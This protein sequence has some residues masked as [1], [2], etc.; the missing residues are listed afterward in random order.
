MT[1]FAEINADRPGRILHML[2]VI[3]T[4]ARSNK[5]E[6]SEVAE[7][8]APVRER[9]DRLAPPE[10]SA[11]EWAHLTTP[12]APPASAPESIEDAPPAESCYPPIPRHLTTA[13][14]EVALRERYAA[15]PWGRLAI[16]A[17]FEPINTESAARAAF[18]F[19]AELLAKHGV[20]A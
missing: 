14:R 4:S 17:G 15:E 8:L 18:R 11:P 10:I 6:P 3:E 20:K 19:C 13:E 2:D 7:L 1:R 12:P 9:L 5:A 16:A